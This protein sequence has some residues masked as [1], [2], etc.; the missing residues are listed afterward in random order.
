MTTKRIALGSIGLCLALAGCGGDPASAQ[1]AAL[2]DNFCLKLDVVGEELCPHKTGGVELSYVAESTHGTASATVTASVD[3]AAA[4]TIGTIATSDWT[5]V[6]GI[7]RYSG[8]ADLAL[9][10]GSHSIVLCVVQ[11][12]NSQCNPAFDLDVAC[13]KPKCNQGVGNGPEGCDPGNSDSNQPSNDEDGGTP[14]NPGRAH[15]HKH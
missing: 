3:G 1:S 15:N 4:I 6:G 2:T 14:G 13:E 7:E 12:A 9:A 11:G 10:D 8:K 5:I